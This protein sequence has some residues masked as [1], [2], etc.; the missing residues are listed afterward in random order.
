MIVTELRQALEE[1][2]RQGLGGLQVFMDVGGEYWQ[3]VRT[4]AA[5]TGLREE[6]C[7]LI[8]NSGPPYDCAGGWEGKDDYP[9]PEK[10]PR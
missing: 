4:L 3:H 2:E 10:G 6:R 5:T 9:M 1:L 8:N 7:A